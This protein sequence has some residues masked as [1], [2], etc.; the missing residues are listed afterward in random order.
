MCVCEGMCTCV[1]VYVSALCVLCVCVCLHCVLCV[2]VCVSVLC[3]LCMCVCVCV[4]VCGVCMCVVCSCVC[5][6][7]CACV[8]VC[9]C[10][11]MHLCLFCLCMIIL[12]VP[13]RCGPLYCVGFQGCIHSIVPT[14]R[15]HSLVGNVVVIGLDTYKLSVTYNTLHTAG[16][17]TLVETSKFS[18]HSSVLTLNITIYMHTEIRTKNK[19]AHT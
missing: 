7:A 14:N 13:C 15:G 19:Y 3:V 8:H 2:Y 10:V 17:W 11:C 16:C 5:M 1:C 4:C 18:L 12:I 9:M 6:C